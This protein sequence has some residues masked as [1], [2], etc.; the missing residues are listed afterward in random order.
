[1]LPDFAC[2]CWGVTGCWNFDFSLSQGLVVEVGGKADWLA[3]ELGVDGRIAHERILHS[4]TSFF[5]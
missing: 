1:M 2:L 3:G 5:A 4:P